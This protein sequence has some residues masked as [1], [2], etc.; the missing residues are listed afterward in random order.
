MNKKLSIVFSVL[1]ITLISAAHVSADVANPQF[2]TKKCKP[3]EKEVTATYSSD[4]PF[5]R[6]THDETKKYANNPNYYE[7]TAEGHSFGGT[8]KYCQKYSSSNTK[9][10]GA[11]VGGVVI[12]AVGG[13]F[14]IRRNSAR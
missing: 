4:K 1:I 9:L 7:L 12:V 3:G 13:L 2:S 6:R 11:V 5:G 8:I 10:I 14:L